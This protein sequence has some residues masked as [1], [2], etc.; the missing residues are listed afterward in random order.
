MSDTEANS[1]PN[2]NQPAQPPADSQSDLPR[3]VVGTEWQGPLPPPHLLAEYE[4]QIPGS[5]DRILTMGEKGQQHRMDMEREQLNLESVT[6]QSVNEAIANE[7]SRGIWGI[8]AATIIALSGMGVGGWLTS[9]GHGGFGL[10]FLFVSIGS[11]VGTFLYRA[12]ERRS[13]VG[14][15]ADDSSDH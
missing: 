11:L 8:V 14:S 4:R 3:I 1:D 5:S 15:H 12:L 13:S 10:G 9:I 7:H 6:L 2:Q